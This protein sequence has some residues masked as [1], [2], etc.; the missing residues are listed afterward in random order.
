MNFLLDF[1]FIHSSESWYLPGRLGQRARV[2]NERA[3]AVDKDYETAARKLD[4][5]HHG[6]PD[7]VEQR[8]RGLVGPVFATLR[9][10]ESVRGL[11]FGAYAESS[12]DVTRLMEIAAEMGAGAGWREMGSR[13]EQEARG[14]LVAYLR[15][16]WG[17]AAAI[18]HARMRLAR[19]PYVGRSHA[20]ARA[21]GSVAGADAATN[22]LISPTAV[23]A[24]A[25]DIGR[26]RQAQVD[27]RVRGRPVAT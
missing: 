2:V 6:L 3:A 18:A 7:H 25:A 1:K 5:R 10:F 23:E 27:T 26:R 15:R 24:D 11:V 21:M 4:H 13:T 9:Q 14:F 22:H 8:R 17:T 20:E 19:L 16:R 12:R